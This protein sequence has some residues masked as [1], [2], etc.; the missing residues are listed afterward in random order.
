VV[1]AS[2]GDGDG[3]F[4]GRGFS[5][6]RPNDCTICVQFVLIQNQDAQ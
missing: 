2:I 3:S 5:G 6:P 4:P 1:A